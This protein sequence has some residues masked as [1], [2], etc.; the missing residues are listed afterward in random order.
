ML[1]VHLSAMNIVGRIAPGINL[2]ATTARRIEIGLEYKSA[3]RHIIILLHHTFKVLLQHIG[4]I[5]VALYIIETIDGCHI[6]IRQHTTNLFV[7]VQDDTLVTALGLS[8]QRLSG[9][10]INN[11]HNYCRHNQQYYHNSKT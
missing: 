7:L 11:S 1:L 8:G 4:A 6:Y 10:T 5:Q 2:V 9:Y 3:T